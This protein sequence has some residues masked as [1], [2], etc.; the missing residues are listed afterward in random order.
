MLKFIKKL[1]SA[2]DGF[3]KR[4][5]GDKYWWVNGELHRVG[6]PALERVDG[7]KAWYLN[8]K[9]HREDGP[10]VEGLNGYREWYVNGIRYTSKKEYAKAVKDYKFEQE[11]KLI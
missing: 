7:D 1:F 6:G 8:G 10:A 4:A 11:D 3:V 5:N 2:K 9:L